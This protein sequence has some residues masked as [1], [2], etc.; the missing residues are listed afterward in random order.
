[1][2]AATSAEIPD[3]GPLPLKSAPPLVPSSAELASLQPE[4]EWMTLTVAVLGLRGLKSSV[5]AHR[6]LNRTVYIDSP[7]KPYVELD[8]GKSARP[9]AKSGSRRSLLAK[10]ASKTEATLEGTVL[11][12]SLKG[13]QALRTSAKNTPSATSPCYMEVR[14]LQTSL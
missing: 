14:S 6:L 4:R 3:V 9:S 13:A 10:A 1:M 7:S 11:G 5:K 8:A 2:P 12:S